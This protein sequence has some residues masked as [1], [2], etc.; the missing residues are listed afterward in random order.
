MNE[1]NILY[2]KEGFVFIKNQKNNFSLSFSM[3]N[4]N[5]LL[6]KIIDFNLVKLVYDLNKDIYEK[7]SLNKKNDNE[8]I[9]VMLMKNLFEEFGMPQR[10]SYIRM[11]KYEQ[12]N[13]ISFVSESIKNDRPEGIPDEAEQ[14]LIR[15]LINDCEIINPHK[16][17]F[18][19]QIQFEDSVH[20]PSFIEKMVGLLLF[21]I[22]K[23]VKQFIENVRI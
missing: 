3:E 19:C 7:V 15:S 18:I 16:I 8:A 17:Q 11:Q 13:K 20:I 21:K 1:S 14:M 4:N 12:E 5:I 2:S 6:S 23:R 10:Y 22:F 9:M